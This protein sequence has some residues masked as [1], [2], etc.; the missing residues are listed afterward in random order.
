M[1][2]VMAD[3]VVID[4]RNFVEGDLVVDGFELNSKAR[5]SIHAVGAEFRS[6]GDMF[7]GGWIIN[8]ETREPV[9]ILEEADTRRFK[10]SKYLREFEGE[11]TLSEGQYEVYYNAGLPYYYNNIGLEIKNLGKAF[12]IIG[13]IF[14]DED[15]YVFSY[16]IEDFDELFLVV[17]ALE[18]IFTNFN[19]VER[20]REN[21]IVDFSKPE[22][23]F[24]EK[25]GFTLNRDM[26]VKIIAIGE[27]SSSDRVFVDY[28][29]IY[30]AESREKV[31]QMDKWNTSW[32]G[33]GRKNRAF[34]EDINL[35]AG[36]Y[37]ACFVTDDSHSFG[38]WNVLPPYDPLHYGLMIYASKKE[39]LEFVDDFVD[40]YTEPVI[41]Q[42]TKVRNNQYKYKGFTLKKKTNLHVY[43]IGEFG[44]Q[45]EF[46]DYGWIEDIDNNEIVWEMTE[47]NTEHAGGASKNRRF[48]GFITLPA[49]SYVVYYVTDDSHA[50]RR[51][52]ASA[53]IEKNMWGIT[54]YGAGRDFDAESVTLF[55][56]IPEDGNILVNLTGIGDDEEVRQRFRLDSSQR[57]HIFAVGEGR[58]GIMYDYGWIENAD[59]D[60]V[61]WEMTYRKTRHAGG[62]R[63]NRMVDAHLFLEKGRYIAYF[64]TD[65][66]HS[67][68]D[69]N[70]SRPDNPQKWGIK[71]TLDKE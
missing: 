10:R 23:D 71:I 58:D 53:P 5:L 41:V 55:D 68:P 34:V 19:P 33:G 46:V 25:K 49:G 70:A 37:V 1:I 27:Y 12:K 13:D 66:S 9:W 63:K 48:V 3:E 26:T 4:M 8:A 35:A 22:N 56:E 14:D 11:I 59:T 21:A 65:D 44:Y 51:W 61:I 60:E 40:T 50:Y 24:Y 31:W 62:D 42:I 47:D 54:I 36:H 18:G 30:D 45:D 64:M 17:E 16:D 2:Q 20:I 28:G 7:A 43:A 6:R 15:D 57:I 69:F 52:N 67:F 29:W 38:A 32:A 39:D